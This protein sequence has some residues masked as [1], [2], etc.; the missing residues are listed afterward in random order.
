M[1]CTH[2]LHDPEYTVL[3][4]WCVVV[5]EIISCDFY[6]I[7]RGSTALHEAARRGNTELVE[8]LIRSGADVN[9][10]DVVS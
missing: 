10:L 6:I 8:T 5:D 9:A 1:N 3:L 7:Q 2:H 4:Y